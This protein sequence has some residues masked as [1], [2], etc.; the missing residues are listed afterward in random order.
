MSSKP[1]G[2]V[3]ESHLSHLPRPTFYAEDGTN[4]PRNSVPPSVISVPTPDRLEVAKA[5]QSDAVK[6]GRGRPK[7]AGVSPWV[8][9]GLSRRTWYRR[10]KA[11]T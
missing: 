5:A 2:E 1:R 6:R 7:K 4:K 9:A 8:A 3:K 10:Q 11:G